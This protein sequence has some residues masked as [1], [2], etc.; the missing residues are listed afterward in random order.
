M[1]FWNSQGPALFLLLLLI[2]NA[3]CIDDTVEN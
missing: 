1:A 3:K 2:F